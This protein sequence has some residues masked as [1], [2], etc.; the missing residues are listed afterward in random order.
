MDLSE[1]RLYNKAMKHR[2]F[3]IARILFNFN[4]TKTSIEINLQQNFVVAN[5]YCVIWV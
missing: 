3:L 1:I 2:F 4:V 5:F